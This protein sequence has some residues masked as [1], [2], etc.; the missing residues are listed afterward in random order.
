[1]EDTR[2]ERA[3]KTATI[4]SGT[5]WMARANDGTKVGGGAEAM[6]G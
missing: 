4:A 3:A 2:R 1:L 6:T 5:R